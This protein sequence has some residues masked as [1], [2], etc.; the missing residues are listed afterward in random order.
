VSIKDV[1]T[2]ATLIR[3]YGEFWNPDLVNWK[4]TWDLFGVDPQG[5]TINVFEQR[6]IY[7]LYEDYVPV[8]VGK[9]DKQS[10]GYRLQLHRESQ[11][12]GP[13]WDRFSW[14]GLRR[15]NKKGGIWVF[16]RAT[17]LWKPLNWSRHL[18]HC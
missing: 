13:R 10:I 9:A 15:I 6:G 14:F 7:V 3:A 4:R 2:S 17:F 12:K 11:R 5:R 18:K 1:P 16:S 8:Y